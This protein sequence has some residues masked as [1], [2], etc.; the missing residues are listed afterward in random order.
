MVYSGAR[1]TLI[2]EKYWKSEISK[3]STFGGLLQIRGG[4]KSLKFR[5]SAFNKKPFKLDH[6]EKDPSRW[7][8]PLSL[9]RGIPVDGY[10]FE[11]SFWL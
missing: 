6:F 7:T 9:Y 10:C 1:G 2:Y 4:Q 3:I 5:A 8:V 11:Y